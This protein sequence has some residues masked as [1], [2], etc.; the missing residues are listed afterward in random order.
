[1]LLFLDSVC[2]KEEV[3]NV[4]QRPG[5]SAALDSTGLLLIEPLDGQTTPIRKSHVW[6]ARQS[7]CVALRL[8]PGVITL[9]DSKIEMILKVQKHTELKPLIPLTACCAICPTSGCLL[10]CSRS[11][12]KLQHVR[13]PSNKATVTHVTCVYHFVLMQTISKLG[14]SV[15]LLPNNPLNNCLL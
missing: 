4:L 13:F 14:L 6:E 3:W 2:W 5:M 15:W 9:T 8:A 1:M 12:F 7:M 10:Q 11:L